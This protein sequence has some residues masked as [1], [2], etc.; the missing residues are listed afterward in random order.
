MSF[1]I[2]AL[3][4]DQ[5]GYWYPGDALPTNL[6]ATGAPQLMEGDANLNDHVSGVDA[7]LIARFVVGLETLSVDQEK[8]ADTT[9]DGNVTGA[10][11][12][13]IAQWVI[14]PDGTGGV[15]KKDLWESPADDDMQA[16]VACS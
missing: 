3:G 6:T 14:D 7:L 10:D 16:P 13:H 11:M 2:G 9:D 8:C 4:A 5:V 12:L 15:L 1:K